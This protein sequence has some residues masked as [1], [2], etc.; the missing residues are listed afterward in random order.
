MNDYELIERGYQTLPSQRA[1]H[2]PL[3]EVG[4]FGEGNPVLRG[5]LEDEGCDGR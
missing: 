4:G 2:L 3:P 1:S 5:H